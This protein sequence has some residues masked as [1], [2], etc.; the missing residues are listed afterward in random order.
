MSIFDKQKFKKIKL[1]V[2][3]FDGVMTDN[4]VLVSEDGKEA[5]FCNRADGLGVEMLQK[6]GI[7]VVVISTEK[8]EVVKARCKKLQI[9]CYNGIDKKIDVF[10]ELVAKF[11]VDLKEVCFIGNDVNDL[12]CIEKAGIGVAVAD[13]YEKV[14]KAADYVTSKKGGDGAVR[15]IADLF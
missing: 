7:K 4:R 5:V 1:L 12:E 6:S 2:L 11:G 9:E 3:D 8:N 10:S 15:E 14:L 13:S